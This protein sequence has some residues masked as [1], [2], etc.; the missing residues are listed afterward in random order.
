MLGIRL[1]NRHIGKGGA[2]IVDLYMQCSELASALIARTAAELQGVEGLCEQYVDVIGHKYRAPVAGEAAPSRLQAELTNKRQY[3]AYLRE[4]STAFSLAGS[5]VEELS[6]LL[7]AEMQQLQSLVGNRSSVP[8]EQVYPRFDSLAKLWAAFREEL[9]LLQARQITLEALKA[10]EAAFNVTLKP[11]DLVA[12]RAAR[13]AAAAMAGGGGGGDGLAVPLARRRRR[14]EARRGA[15]GRARRRRPPTTPRTRSPRRRPPTRCATRGS[16]SKASAS[17][18][19]F[20]ATGSCSRRRRA[21]SRSTATGTTASS[22][23]PRATPSSRRRRGTT[24]PSSP[25]RGGC[26]S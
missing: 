12:A 5:H 7:L 19:A 1:F 17:T 18:R 21:R 3:T 10:F 9:T 26:R 6:S 24:P 14:R 8:K 13:R 2:G 22:T 16:T 25:S 15:R 11:D 20:S 23:P 4:L